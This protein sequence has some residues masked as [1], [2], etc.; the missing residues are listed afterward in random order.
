[1]TIG[2]INHLT[3]YLLAIIRKK[4]RG[5]FMEKVIKSIRL[6]LFFA[7]IQLAFCSCIFWSGTSLAL[8]Q[9]CFYFL[10][11]LLG[12][13]GSCAFMHY[14]SN[15]NLKRDRL[16]DRSRFIF[17][18][19]SMMIVVNLCGVGLVLS[20]TIVTVNLLQKEAV[21][22]ILPSFFFLFGVDLV[23]FLPFRKWRRL[24]KNSSSKEVRFSIIIISI[25]IFL[26]NPITILS[27]TFY[28]GLG[29]LFLSF[30][31]PKN[32]RQEV[33]FYGHLIRD[34]LFVVCTFLLW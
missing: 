30:L 15:H 9:S 6:L 20:D 29:A 16:I 26:R 5:Y 18:F 14:L 27:I 25:L 3:S 28:I 11:A 4:Y 8:K 32:L 31:F 23:T 13:S 7:L 19:Y 34:I 12:L 21:E 24:Q 10:L 22:L 2:K 33:S 1:M 17:L